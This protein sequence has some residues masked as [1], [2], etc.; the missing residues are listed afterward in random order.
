MGTPYTI[1]SYDPAEIAEEHPN[2][3][4]TIETYFNDLTDEKKA[5]IAS[6][7]IG[8]CHACHNADSNCQCWN[9]E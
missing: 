6:L 2:L 5:L 1:F 3:W 9:D 4:A 8:T 7:V